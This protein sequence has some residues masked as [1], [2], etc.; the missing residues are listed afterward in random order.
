[1]GTDG[2][3][4]TQFTREIYT[5][6]CAMLDIPGINDRDLEM[7]IKDVVFNFALE[8]ALESLADPRVLAKV[9]WLCTIIT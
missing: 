8:Q 5:E 1:M 2:C 7:F 6:P 9:A 3:G 4:E